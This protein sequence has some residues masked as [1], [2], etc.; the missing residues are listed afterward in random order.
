MLASNCCFKYLFRDDIHR[1]ELDVEK[2]IRCKIMQLI[3]PS[4]PSNIKFTNTFESAVENKL[5]S[6]NDIKEAFRNAALV[7]A[8]GSGVILVETEI[9]YAAD[10]YVGVNPWTKGSRSNG[11]GYNKS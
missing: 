9:D 6:M 3:E 11:Q 8:A 7:L 1:L 5:L 10:L 4:N 2:F